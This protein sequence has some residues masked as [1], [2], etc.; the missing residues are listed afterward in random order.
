MNSFLRF[1]DWISEP[2]FSWPKSTFSAGAL[3][4]WRTMATGQKNG[5]Q[6]RA[7]GEWQPFVSSGEASQL[8]LYNSLTRGKEIFK[9]I[10]DNQLKFYICGPT[11]YDSAHMGHAR[12]YLSFD[13]VRRVLET[14]FNYDVTY[15]M[16]ITDIDDKIIKRARQGYLFDEYTKTKANW[17]GLS[18]DV[19]QALAHF[20]EKV[21]KETDNDKKKMLQ[22]MVSLRY[23]KFIFF[24][25]S[26]IKVNNAVKALEAD[27]TKSNKITDEQC[28]QLVLASK[29]ILSDW[30]DEKLGGTVQEMSVFEKL[31]RR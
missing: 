23:L 25:F 19:K 9:P 18:S 15:V 26:I 27:A 20:N 24:C 5:V 4:T 10:N 29:D 7:Q 21:E 3:S 1:V 12:A 6:K 28:E 13:I 11:V 16:N 14:Y 8:R 30:L 22:E 17:S 2:R 31:A